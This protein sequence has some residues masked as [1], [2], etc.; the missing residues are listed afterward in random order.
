MLHLKKQHLVLL[1]GLDGTGRLFGPLL[2]ILPA[3]WES[4]VVTYPPDRRL[5]YEQLYPCIREVMPWNVPYTLMAESFGGPLALQFAVEQPQ[6]VQA[7]VLCAP[8]VTNP[9]PRMLG[10][11]ASLLDEIIFRKPPPSSMLRRFLAGH[12]CPTRLSEALDEAFST[13]R[14]EVLARRIRLIM[15]TDSRQVL[16][17]CQAPV[18]CLQAGQDQFISARSLDEIKAVRPDAASAVIDAP[19]LLLQ[20]K[21]RE[22]LLEVQRFLRSIEEAQ[23]TTRLLP[24][25]A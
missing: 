16:E 3:S 22:A 6:G 14:P 1:P 25:A 13:V 11:V 20:R 10:L 2:E 4:A 9:L 5:N 19:H 23:E 8:F 21:P 15:E 18:L 24:L 17:A 12:D 7:V